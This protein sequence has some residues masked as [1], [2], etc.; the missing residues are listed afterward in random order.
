MKVYR[1]S[2]TASTEVDTTLEDL[3]SEIKRTVDNFAKDRGVQ[4]EFWGQANDYSDDDDSVDVNVS[5]T[6]D[7][8]EM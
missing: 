8:T 4:L 3:I 6:L 5:V 7:L 1:K 2:V